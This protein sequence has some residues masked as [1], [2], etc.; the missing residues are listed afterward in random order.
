MLA[1]LRSLA[2][3]ALFWP[4]LLPLRLLALGSQLLAWGLGCYL[5][6]LQVGAAR[7]LEALLN[8]LGRAQGALPALRQPPPCAHAG[9]GAAARP[10]A[11]RRLRCSRHRAPAAEPGR[12]AALDLGRRWGGRCSTHGMHAARRPRSCSGLDWSA[13]L[14]P[15]QPPPTWAGRRACR[16]PARRPTPTLA[17][18]SSWPAV[19]RS[20][21]PPHQPPAPICHL[22][23]CP[24]PAERVESD[25]LH[26]AIMA[27]LAAAAAPAAEPAVPQPLTP[28]PVAPAADTAA[29]PA[30]RAGPAGAVALPPTEPQ[31]PALDAAMLRAVARSDAPFGPL[32][33]DAAVGEWQAELQAGAATGGPGPPRVQRTQQLKLSLQ[34]LRVSRGAARAAWGSLL[35]RGGTVCV[36]VGCGCVAASPNRRARSSH[37]SRRGCS[38]QWPAGARGAP[39]CGF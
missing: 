17:P 20:R 16:C 31:H 3:L 1:A 18:V 22:V 14:A 35:R 19:L 39:A 11:G 9:A 23:A 26:A 6:L 25:T 36:W 15:L 27:A 34:E 38:P 32:S 21:M 8:S 24:A 37:H 13:S 28:P 2:L 10:P 29:A 4:V 30:A 7:T 5:G 12:R 33:M